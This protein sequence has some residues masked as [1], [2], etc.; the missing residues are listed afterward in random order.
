MKR[1]RRTF[2]AEFKAKIAIEAIK[3]E[4]TVSELAQIHQVHPNL[5]SLWK[6]EFLSNAGKVFEGNK[7]EEEEI[8]RLKKENNELV[9]Q[10][11]ELTVDIKW[12]KKKLL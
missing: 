9:H 3:E 11:G 4:K 12:L 10:I 7:D 5:I 6:K 1:S 8:H 2:S